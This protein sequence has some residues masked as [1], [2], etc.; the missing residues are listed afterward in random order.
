MQGVASLSMVLA[1]LDSRLGAYR[2]V[3]DA[4]SSCTTKS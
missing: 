2:A 1:T 3:L 4:F